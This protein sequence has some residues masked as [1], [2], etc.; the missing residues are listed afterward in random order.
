MNMLNHLNVYQRG[1][2]RYDFRILAAEN[3]KILC[4][5]SQGYQNRSEAIEIGRRVLNAQGWIATDP[6]IT[7]DDQPF[8]DR[9]GE[10]T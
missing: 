9:T 8:I 6:V 4:H 7:F 2:G 3:N 10:H 1:D 5:S